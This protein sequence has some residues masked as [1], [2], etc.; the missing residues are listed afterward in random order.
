MQF[1][2]DE[3]D[4]EQE[5]AIIHTMTEIEQTILDLGKLLNTSD[6]CL[7]SENKSRN[8]ELRRLPPSSKWHSPTITPQKIITEQID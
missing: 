6:V 5:D 3:M 1:K 8:D 4:T 2:I 7:V